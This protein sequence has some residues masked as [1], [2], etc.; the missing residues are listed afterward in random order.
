MLLVRANIDL[1]LDRID[2]ARSA[3]EQARSLG[4]PEARLAQLSGV[5]S[6]AEGQWADA[7]LHFRRAAELSAGSLP[8]TPLARASEA[9]ALL[10]QGRIDE[11]LSLAQQARVAL[12]A[13]DERYAASLAL[14][15]EVE[16][17]ARLVRGELDDAEVR[18]QAASASM[19]SCDPLARADLDYA[20]GLVMLRRGDPDGRAWIARAH[21]SYEQL[22]TA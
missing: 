10:H 4:A 19:T 21:A 8:G 2:E 11:A 13:P 22:G 18:L 7:E 9:E 17:L 15:L 6:L 16:G 20:L 5:I 14:P 1:H 12:E 3:I